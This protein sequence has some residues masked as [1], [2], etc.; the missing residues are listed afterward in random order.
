VWISIAE[1]PLPRDEL[2]GHPVTHRNRWH[3]GGCS[4]GDP[5]IYSTG[6]YNV[7]VDG[8]IQLVARQRLV[9]RIEIHTG[10]STAFQTHRW[11][12]RFL[13]DRRVDEEKKQ[14]HRR[15]HAP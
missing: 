13:S 11:R 6:R 1:Q 8:S 3:G 14:Q 10:D 5:E 7:V 4:G 9:R 12:R 2:I 15:T